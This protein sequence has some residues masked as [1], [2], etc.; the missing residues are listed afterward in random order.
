MACGAMVVTTA[1]TVM[2]E[3]AGGA[4]A[5]APAGDVGAL[6][7]RLADALEASNQERTAR[8]TR[9]RARAELFTWDACLDQ[10]LVAYEQALS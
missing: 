3:V 7:E 1:E 6:A 4:A 9:A 2:A 10:H 8:A 5:L